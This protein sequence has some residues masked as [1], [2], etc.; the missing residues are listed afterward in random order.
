MLIVTPVFVSQPQINCL[1]NSWHKESKERSMKSSNGHKQTGV[2]THKINEHTHRWSVESCCLCEKRKLKRLE[3]ISVAG[4]SCLTWSGAGWYWQ[5]LQG[6]YGG[7]GGAFW[8]PEQVADSAICSW[9]P[10]LKAAWLTSTQ[11]LREKSPTAKAQQQLNS[12]VIV[13]FWP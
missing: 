9:E 11:S 4:A 3:C 8:K 13:V 12:C 7:W 2:C 1:R 6:H 5:Q 10:S